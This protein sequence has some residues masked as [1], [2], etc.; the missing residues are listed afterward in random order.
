MVRCCIDHPAILKLNPVNLGLP[1]RHPDIPEPVVLPVVTQH[2]ACFPNQVR[3]PGRPA[4]R[5]H[6]SAACEAMVFFPGVYVFG[7]KGIV[8]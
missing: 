8:G 4:P 3:Y 6:E 2:L 5:L 7:F 1:L